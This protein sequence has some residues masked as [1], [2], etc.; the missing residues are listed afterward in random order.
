MSPEGWFRVE[1][2]APK[3]YQITEGG[4]WKMF[5]LIGEDRALA[6]DSGVG[7]GDLKALEESLTDRPI[8]HILTH[9]HWDHIGSSHRWESVG[10][11]PN[12]K[13]CLAEDHTRR[14]RE[15]FLNW[16]NG[17]PF[18]EGF[19]PE[20]HTIPPAKFGHEVKEGDVID[21]GGRTLR[22]W[23]T[24]GH[25]PCSISLLDDKEGVLITGDLVK[26]FQP[27]NLRVTTAA[28]SDYAPS[29]RKLEKVA[30]ENEVKWV[31]SGHTDAF[32]D[33]SIIGEMAKF[34]EKLEAG[35]HDP[36]RKMKHKDFGELDVYQAARFS[37]WI[38]DHARR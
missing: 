38:K 15:V 2:F 30:A 8:D 35:G 14:L 29:L 28:L 24:P 12:G 32:P 17:L 13:D 1:E 11:H 22:V 21:L 31:C 20:T 34:M 19:D 7:A 27:L 18:P 9:T 25:S 33:T 37:V 10:A 3:T 23:D 4:R 36:P 5:L 6:L 16:G 26:P